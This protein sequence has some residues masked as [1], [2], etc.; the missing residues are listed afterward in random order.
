MP[1]SLLGE[2]SRYTPKTNSVTLW[3]FFPVKLPAF[4][5]YRAAILFAAVPASKRLLVIIEI[6]SVIQGHLYHFKLFGCSSS[7]AE[8]TIPQ[9]PSLALLPACVFL[10]SSASSEGNDCHSVKGHMFKQYKTERGFAF[11]G[12]VKPDLG[13]LYRW[14]YEN[15]TI[16]PQL[17]KSIYAYSNLF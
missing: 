5:K 10:A 2:P 14:W 8:R 17:E 1:T 13:R 9:R 11:K 6:S 15:R 7:N 16:I 3:G 12:D 4:F